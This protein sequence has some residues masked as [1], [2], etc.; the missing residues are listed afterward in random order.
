MQTHGA[1]FG[2]DRSRDIVRDM[3][4]LRINILEALRIAPPIAAIPRLLQEDGEHSGLIL[5]KGAS[6]SFR[7]NPNP[8]VHPLRLPLPA[9]TR[10]CPFDF[11]GV[12]RSDI[13]HD[14][15]DYNPY[16]WLQRGMDKDM[17][18]TTGPRSVVEADKQGEGEELTHASDSTSATA[19][20]D[21]PKEAVVTS[22]PPVKSGL[23]IEPLEGEE[24]M[25]M[26]EIESLEMPFGAGPRSCVGRNLAMGEMSVFLA[27]LFRGYDIEVH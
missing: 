1:E 11:K 4:K 12:D 15:F 5:P 26:R 25:S 9:E 10:R 6:V 17:L 14:A 13:D 19:V 3:E 16:R 8:H 23:K 21:P 20:L 18:F 22:L 2:A 7:T 27:E 24:S